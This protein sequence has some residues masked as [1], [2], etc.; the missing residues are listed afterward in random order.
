MYQ[1]KEMIRLLVGK[2]GVEPTV[3]LRHGFT[4]RCNRHYAHFPLVAEGLGFEPRELS[5]TSFQDSHLKPLGQPPY[6][7]YGTMQLLLSSHRR[8]MIVFRYTT[9]LSVIFRPAIV[10]PE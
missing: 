1:F 6:Y 9:Y 7:P 3:F 5:P 4:V 2:V 8:C 10:L